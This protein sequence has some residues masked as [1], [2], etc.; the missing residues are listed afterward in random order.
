MMGCL[1]IVPMEPLNS[2]FNDKRIVLRKTSLHNHFSIFI[3]ETVVVAYNFF[4]YSSMF[5]ISFF[6]NSLSYRNSNNA[7][8]LVN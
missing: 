8:W 5:G 1:I 4:S 2:I 3:V 6:N 7:V